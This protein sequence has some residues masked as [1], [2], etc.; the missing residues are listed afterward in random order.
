LEGRKFYIE[1]AETLGLW[2][3][4]GVGILAIVVSNHD[5]ALQ[6]KVMQ[7]QQVAMQGQLTEMKGTG[8]QTNQMIDTNRQLAEA[9]GKQAQAAIDS[10]KTAQENMVASQRAWVGPRN[11]K[12]TTGPELEKPLDII[13]EYQ[14][15]GREPALDTIFDTEAFVATKEEDS[16]G[17]APNRVNDFIGKCKIKWTPTQKG[18]VFPAGST[19]SAYELTRALD[20]KWIDQDVI[21]GAKLIFIDG[22]FVYKTAGGIRRSSF[23]YFFNSKKT[24]PSNWNICQI[25][26]DAD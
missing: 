25:G 14:N 20:A 21:D 8:V 13:I 11:A 1:L 26:N 15:S 5:S 6:T 23:C 19:G 7:D 22:C 24:K 18:V 3:A 2:V 9:A 17:A 10:A 16:S 4:A 12:S